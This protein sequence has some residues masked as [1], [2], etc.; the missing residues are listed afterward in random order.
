M[1]MA[2]LL[3]LEIVSWFA[4][5]LS[6]LMAVLA[7]VVATRK[8]SRTDPMRHNT[9]VWGHHPVSERT[10]LRWSRIV[11]LSNTAFWLHVSNKHD[12]R[13]TTKPQSSSGKSPQ[14]SL[15]KSSH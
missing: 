11:K 14:A 12:V 7:L 5:V 9:E 13:H 1:H 10:V 4:L 8:A 3:L 15:Q 6:A 2:G